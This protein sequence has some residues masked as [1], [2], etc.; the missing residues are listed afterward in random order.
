MLH[1]EAAKS[2]VKL[3]GNTIDKEIKALKRKI[4]VLDSIKNQEYQFSRMTPFAWFKPSSVGLYSGDIGVYVIWHSKLFY[5][6]LGLGGRDPKTVDDF[7]PMY[8]GEG[9]I[10]QR[11]RRHFAVY[12]NLGEAIDHGSSISSSPVGSK[13]WPYDRNYM[14]WF[15]SVCKTQTKMQ[16]KM[17]EEKMFWELKPKF[18][19]FYSL[20]SNKNL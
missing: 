15:V 5:D 20:A 1:S 6:C 11:I 13:M 9:V 3:H 8:V 12:E 18:N 16:A 14:H 17:L 4:S 19:N 7:K 2:V 10:S